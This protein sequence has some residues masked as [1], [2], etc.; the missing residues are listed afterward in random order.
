VKYIEYVVFLF[1]TILATS[2]VYVLVNPSSLLTPMEI[3]KYEKVDAGFSSNTEIDEEKV[4]I[5]EDV[6]IMYKKN[7]DGRKVGKNYDEIDDTIYL[8]DG[9]SVSRLKEVCEHEV[10][11]MKGIG[12]EDH[13][14]IRSN[15]DQVD[16]DICNRF[17]FELG[18]YLN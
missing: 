8:E 5:I 7:L 17:L 6:K 14:Y 9:L 1:G 18:S 4:F 2:F 16:S 13:E 11:H 10:M 15:E 12:E 3:N